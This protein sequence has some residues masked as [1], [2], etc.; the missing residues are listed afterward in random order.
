MLGP[1]VGRLQRQQERR[2]PGLRRVDNGPGHVH[3]RH[4][5]LRRRDPHA[6]LHRRPVGCVLA[7][8]ERRRRGCGFEQHD[9]G[10]EARAQQQP[11]RTRA[12]SGP[13]RTSPIIFLADEDDCS[14]SHS[15]AA[16]RRQHVAR[17]AAVVPLHALGHHLRPGR[18]RSERDEPGRPEGHVPLGRQRHLPRRRSRTTSTSSRASRPTRTASSSPRSRAS[19][20]RSRSSCAPPQGGTTPEPALAHSCSY[21]GSDDKPEVARPGDPHQGAARQ[22]PNRSTFSTI[23]Q[24]DLS[25]GLKLIADLL[26]L[27]IGRPVHRWHARRRRPEHRR[28]PVRLLGLGRHELRQVESARDGPPAVRQPGDADELGEQA[29]LGDR[30]AT[31]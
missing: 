5:Q 28:Q 2:P 17:H 13:T 14:M 7:D 16:R 9:R 22:F 15:S 21:T 8:G 19:R 4:A 26:K 31:R 12:S 20:R 25:G 10:G 29:V 11:E 30:N 1:S 3:F 24:Q 27:V 6:E 23:C 18:R